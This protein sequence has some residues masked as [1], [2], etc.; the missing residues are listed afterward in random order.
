ML[1]NYC[2]LP[3]YPGSPTDWTNLYAALQICQNISVSVI[4][5]R[6]TIISLD[7]QLYAKAMQLKAKQDINEKFVFRLGELHIVFAFLK[8]VDKYI[9]CSG[10]NQIF[11]EA[12]IYGSTT[13]DQI[14][15]G[16]HMKRAMEAYM[17]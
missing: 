13:S 4:S 17:V 6:K 1:T 12:N 3:L 15:N 11:V 10:L 8:T 14:L 9:E 16:K 7:L 5:N 2:S